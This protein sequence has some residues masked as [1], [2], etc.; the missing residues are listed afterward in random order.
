VAT[1]IHFTVPKND[2]ATGAPWIRLTIDMEVRVSQGRRT[3]Q[4]SASAVSS[5]DKPNDEHVNATLWPWQ[6]D[7]VAGDIRNTKRFRE[8]A[9][10]LRQR[11]GQNGVT[12]VAGMIL[13]DRVTANLTL[14]HAPF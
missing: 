5:A 9:A 11:A 8:L 7:H 14:T 3:G 10:F 6:D 13:A 1:S 12:L 4:W 2:S